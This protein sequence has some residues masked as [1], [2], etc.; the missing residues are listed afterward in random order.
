MV[1]PTG[2]RD[3]NAKHLLYND[4]LGG[5]LDFR[6]KPEFKEEYA[7]MAEQ[8]AKVP[9]NQFSYIIRSSEALCRLLAL[10]A[11]LSLE[12]RN[13][14]HANDRVTLKAIA[15]ERISATIEALNAYIIA[16]R[17]E[18]YHD[19]KTFGFDIIELRLGGLKERLLSTKLTLEHF[20]NNEIEK[21]EQ[22]EEKLLE[23]NVDNARTWTKISS[24][25]RNF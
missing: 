22:L 25:V 15:A 23:S 10:K 2:R 9:E 20:L 6:V 12:I 4:P 8:L 21:I 5:W 19:A 7:E 17:D 1:D 24:T 11:T 16:A 14:Y 13:A 3:V 18:W